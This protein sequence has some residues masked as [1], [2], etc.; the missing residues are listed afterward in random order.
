MVLLMV[1]IG[2]GGD[3]VLGNIFPPQYAG[4]DE[5]CP[6]PSDATPSCWMVLNGESGG[7]KNST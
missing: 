4:A 2:V 7:I 1:H 3:L 6:E 5:I